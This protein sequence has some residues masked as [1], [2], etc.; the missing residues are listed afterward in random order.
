[1]GISAHLG[2]T[3]PRA[4]RHCPSMA[5]N[6]TNVWTNLATSTAGA[7]IAVRGKSFIEDGMKLRQAKRQ[8]AED[9]GDPD[10]NVV[11]E[12][13]FKHDDEGAIYK[14]TIWKVNPL[15][16]EALDDGWHV[17]GWPDV[18]LQDLRPSEYQDPDGEG[19]AYT[20]MPFQE[21]AVLDARRRAEWLVFFQRGAERRMHLAR[22]ESSTP[23]EARRMR[24]LKGT[25]EK[26]R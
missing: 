1:M 5:T 8:L 14:T 6:E 17:R 18:V 26:A 20:V 25:K 24:P 12:V 4:P 21:A 13:D 2:L 7:L 23:E 15:W 19:Y 10:L 9:F 16:V 3:T 22:T 11:R